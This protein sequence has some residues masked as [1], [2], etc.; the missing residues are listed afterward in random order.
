[1]SN[2]KKKENI[3]CGLHLVDCKK[4]Q[5]DKEKKPKSKTGSEYTTSDL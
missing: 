3:D 4:K 5:K 2:Q 1:M